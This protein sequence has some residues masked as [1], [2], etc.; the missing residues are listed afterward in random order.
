MKPNILFLVFDSFRADKFYG[1]DKTSKTPNIDSLIKSGTYFTQAIPS[2]DGTTISLNSIF[3]G[4]Y[5]FVTG[6]REIKLSFENKNYVEALR[7]FDYNI[8]GM[9]PDLTSFSP[10]YNMC[11]NQDSTYAGGPPAQSLFDGLGQKIIDLLSS[12]MKEPWFYYVHVMDLHWPLIVPDEYSGS[13]YGKNKYEK[14]VSSVDYW[15][16]KIISHIDF[17]KTLVVITADHA[18]TI[19]IDDKDVTEFEPSLDFGLKVGKRLMPK[20]THGF[21]AKLFIKSRR[22]IQNARLSKANKNLTAYEKRSRLPYY[23]ISL[24]D[25]SIRVPL[26]FVGH[27]VKSAIITQQV[28]SVDIFPTIAEIV[29]LS[30]E[31][32]THG[33]SLLPLFA[34]QKLDE[35]PVYLHTMPYQEP[36]SDDMVGIRTSKYKYFRGSRD[37]NHNVNLYDLQ[38]DPF[39]NT[40]IAKENPN[41]VSEMERI[42]TEITANTP[43]MQKQKLNK[44]EEEQIRNELKKLGYV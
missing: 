23:T 35:Q 30:H 8:Y 9:M 31:E 14:V 34:G 17:T 21:G 1:K 12:K 32:K 36:S 29:S 37:P 5:P 27:G 26:L 42:L 4:F 22:I 28:R 15:L 7:D 13:Q 18:T 10:L 41:M 19:P 44:Y 3:T 25:E 33:K 2:A 40:N 38:N 16:G 39:E 43:T 11:I 24:F 20:S 6:T